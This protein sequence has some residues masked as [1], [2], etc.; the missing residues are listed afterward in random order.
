MIDLTTPVSLANLLL[1]FKCF[2]IFKRALSYLDILRFEVLTVMSMQVAVFWDAT[3][4]SV[5][6]V[7]QQFIETYCCHS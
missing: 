2:R 6:E 7:Y 5:V 3:P 1:L 4:C